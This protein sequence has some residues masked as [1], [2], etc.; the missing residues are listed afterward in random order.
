MKIRITMCLY[1]KSFKNQWPVLVCLLKSAPNVF[2]S[3]PKFQ[4]AHRCAPLLF[5][6]FRDPVY[7]GHFWD[8]RL[9]HRLLDRDKPKPSSKSVA[10]LSSPLLTLGNNRP[11]HS[12][13]SVQ[14][15]HSTVFGF[16]R[17]LKQRFNN[18]VTGMIF[19]FSNVAKNVVEVNIIRCCDETFGHW[20]HF[21]L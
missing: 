18:G 8:S 6:W 1:I 15:L 13:N 5:W 7:C 12:K 20:E 10:N 2:L 16:P 4:P 19:V 9:G 11:R 14:G 3:C 17:V 21:S